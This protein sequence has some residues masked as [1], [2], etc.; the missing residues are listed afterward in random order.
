MINKGWIDESKLTIKIGG[1]WI[2]G[3]FCHKNDNNKTIHSI[4]QKK[5]IGLN[6]NLT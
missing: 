1:A 2:M 3:H 6:N 4:I 5:L